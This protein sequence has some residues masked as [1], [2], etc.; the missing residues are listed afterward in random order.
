MTIVTVEMVHTIIC[1]KLINVIGQDFIHWVQK[2]SPN[3][4]LFDHVKFRA[5]VGEIPE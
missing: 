5:S 3:S 2:S 4:V 1:S